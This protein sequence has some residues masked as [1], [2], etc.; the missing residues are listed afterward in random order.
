MINDPTKFRSCD[1]AE[2]VAYRD[3]LY[4]KVGNVYFAVTENAVVCQQL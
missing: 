1:Y 2:A 4:E 3:E